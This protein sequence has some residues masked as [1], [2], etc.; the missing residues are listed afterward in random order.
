VTDLINE[1][2]ALSAL[3]DEV[4]EVSTLLWERGWAERNAGNLSV[5]VTDLVSGY[6]SGI[7]TRGDR[8]L[9]CSHPLLAGRFFLV[10]GSGRRFRDAAKSAAENL[11]IVQMSEDGGAYRF[12]WGGETG[13][14]FK[15]TSEFPAHLR[16]HEHLCETGATE[17]TVLHTHPTELIVLTHLPEYRAEP[18]LNRALWCIHPEVKVNLPRGIGFV[19]YVIPGSEGLA[20]ATVAGFRRGYPVVLWEMHGVVA[21][22]K[23]PSHAFDLIDIATKAAAMVLKCRSVG[24]IPTGLSK[25]QLDE[26]V[27]VFKLKE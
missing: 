7:T 19:P 1:L 8:R 24:H 26:M 22:A 20:Q 2:P 15:P 27:R 18:D 4:V 5:D 21:I 16:V 17:R 3:M 10:T 6:E 9:E 13:P 12:V 14:G 11:C 25:E 23:S